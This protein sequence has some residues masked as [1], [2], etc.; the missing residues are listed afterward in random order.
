MSEAAR[1]LLSNRKRLNHTDFLL[2]KS[3]N[4]YQKIVNSPLRRS[5]SYSQETKSVNVEHSA[6]KHIYEVFRQ[7]PAG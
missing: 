5:L 4:S 3:Y 1:S 2:E 7:K 6:M